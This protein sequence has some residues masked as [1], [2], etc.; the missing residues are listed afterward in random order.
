M[1]D[2]RVNS[3]R[4]AYGSV[5]N[6]ERAWQAAVPVLEKRGLSLPE[7]LTKNNKFYGLGWDIEEAQFKVYFRT[8]DWTKLAPDF[9]DLVGEYD[10]ETHRAEALLSLTFEAQGVSERK[11]YLYPKDEFIP[12][13]ALGYARMITDKRGEVAQTD[14]DPQRTDLYELSDVG[15]QILAK[16]KEVGEELDTVAYKSEEDFTLYFP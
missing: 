12:E 3:S 7:S 2:G 15:K 13:G 10:P 6:P 4:L 16:Y 1:K 14:I 11:I 5:A 9:F 8:L